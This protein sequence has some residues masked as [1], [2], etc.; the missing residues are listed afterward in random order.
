VWTL[1]LDVDHSEVEPPL[2]VFQHTTAELE[3][4]RKLTRSI[5]KATVAAGRETCSSE[6]LEE[7]FDLFWPNLATKIAELRAQDP[8]PRQKPE[9]VTEILAL[10]RQIAE[11]TGRTSWRQEK[12]LAML[13]Q[14]YRYTV[15][16]APPGLEG[17][18]ELQ[19]QQVAV[20]GLT[21]AAGM[22]WQPQYSSTPLPVRSQAVH[23]QPSLV[24]VPQPE[25]EQDI[26]SVE[27]RE[28][29]PTEE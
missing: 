20:D 10:V 26:A 12:T 16:G 9:A 13:H 7:Y 18:K 5:H 22:S 27:E 6:D 14:V 24:H 29:A 25:M 15:G 19:R 17:L 21:V 8:Q 11:R 1:L 3:D 28:S 4:V 2:S 23:H